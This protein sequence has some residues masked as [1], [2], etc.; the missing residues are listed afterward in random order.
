MFAS[1][2]STPEVVQ[3]L[4]E[5]GADVLAKATRQNL[6]A[7]HI[8]SLF[9]PKPDVIDVLL[10]VGISIDSKINNGFTPLLLAATDN[11]NLE[12]AERLAVKGA[13]KGAYD[14]KGRTVLKIIAARIRG[15]GDEYFKISMG[16]NGR[17]M[18]LLTH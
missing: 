18:N 7:L 2:Y 9:N 17:V 4:V 11:R 1:A 5:R 6:N 8:A 16:T 14:S 3:F 10:E 12:V 15:V 13:D